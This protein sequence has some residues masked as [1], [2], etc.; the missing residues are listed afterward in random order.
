MRTILG[1]AAFCL[2]TLSCTGPVQTAG[3][4]TDTGNARVTAMVVDT[5]G[6]PAA[7]VPIRLRRS[8]YVSPLPAL[9]KAGAVIGIDAVTD[10]KGRFD[11]AGIEPGSY[12]IEVNDPASRTAVLMACSLGTD[13]TADLG[14]NTLRPYAAVV[15]AV[16]AGGMS[17]G[18][19]FARVQ[20]LERL[21]VVGANGQYR[22]NDLPAGVFTLQVGAGRAG[23]QPVIIA[24]V[25]ALSGD[26]AVAPSPL[27]A[28]WIGAAIGGETPAGG[29]MYANGRFTITGGGPDIWGSADGFH[30]VY[31]RIAGTAQITAH[32]AAMDFAAP[33]DKAGVMLRQSLDAGS[34][35]YYVSVGTADSTAQ[36]PSVVKVQARFA[37]GDSSRSRDDAGLDSVALPGCPYLLCGAPLWLRVARAGSLVEASVS[38]DGTLWKTIGRDTLQLTDTILVGLAVTS[39]DT[40]GLLR[41]E[42][43]SVDVR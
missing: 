28:P 2:L 35:H 8:D 40:A 25:A 27:P 13:E 33:F 5:G 29:A 23:V 26:T 19:S 21:V 12:R 14:R 39:H 43:D 22:L 24:G 36:A 1:I 32:L 4:T 30:F 38:G 10:S 15:G 6:Q 41:A 7:G 9:A 3:G 18:Y 17:D 37:T 16:D 11:V 31:Q 20:G 42:F 34:M